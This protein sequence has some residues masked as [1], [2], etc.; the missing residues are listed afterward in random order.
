MIFAIEV[1]TKY[2]ADEI[3]LNEFTSYCESLKPLKNIIASGWDHFYDKNGT[4]GFARHRIGP[5]FNQLTF[6]RKTTEAN[7][8]IRDEDNLDLLQPVS[9]KQVASFL[10]KFGY[11]HNTS[12]YKNCFIYKYPTYTMVFYVIYDEKIKEIGRFIEI[13]MSEE[14]LWNDETEAWEALI[15]IEKG[16][17]GLGLSARGRMKKSLY[18]LVTK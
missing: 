4:E 14:S 13:E 7:N 8:F 1:E 15:E 16:C 5:D 11:K 17:K 10:S 9:I 12:I 18:E 3:A 6:K 2:R